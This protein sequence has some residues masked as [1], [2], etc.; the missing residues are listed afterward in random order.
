VWD[1]FWPLYEE[2]SNCPYIYEKLICLQ[3]G[4]PDKNYQHWRWQ[5]RDCDLPKFNA[6]LMLETLRG[7][8]IDDVR[9]GFCNPGSIIFHDLSSSFTHS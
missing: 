2:Y 3:H 4:R 1:E 7:K 6:T 8:R 5:P 9:W